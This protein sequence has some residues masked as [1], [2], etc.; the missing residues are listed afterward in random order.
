ML[1][2]FFWLALYVH[3]IETKDKF[4]SIHFSVKLLVLL[5]SLIEAPKCIIALKHMRPQ[6]NN[7]IFHF[8]LTNYQFMINKQLEYQHIFYLLYYECE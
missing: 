2:Q 3:I 7:A 4:N 1:P 5:H 8:F 6:L